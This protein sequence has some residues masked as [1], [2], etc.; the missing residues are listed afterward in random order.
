[1]K[2]TS[3]STNLERLREQ[4]EAIIKYESTYGFE[5]AIIMYALGCSLRLRSGPNSKLG[6]VKC[7]GYC[8]GQMTWNTSG[9]GVRS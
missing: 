9:D 7:S 1:M 2:D 5:K 8:V 4:V 6:R 3:L